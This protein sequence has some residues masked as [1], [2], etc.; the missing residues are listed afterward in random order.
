MIESK[1]ALSVD[2]FFDL[3]SATDRTWS[4]VEREQAGKGISD[5]ATGPFI[6]NADGCCPVEAVQRKLKLP[7][8]WN[9]SENIGDLF[10]VASLVRAAD[11]WGQDEDRKRLMEACGL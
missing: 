10:M 11:G 1:D 2:D 8:G 4:L 3:L 7:E 5:A 9:E 6:R